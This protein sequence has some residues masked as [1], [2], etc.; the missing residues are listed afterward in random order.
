M[1]RISLALIAPSLITS[2]PHR[3]NK[4]AVRWVVVDPQTVFF[5]NLASI[6]FVPFPLLTSKTTKQ[7]T[8]LTDKSMVSYLV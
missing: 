3:R 6:S 5:S 8:T 2:F 4:L 7:Q 1:F